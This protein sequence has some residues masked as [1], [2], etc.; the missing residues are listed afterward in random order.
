MIVSKRYFGIHHT[1][2]GNI[3]IFS[4]DVHNPHFQPLL[5]TDT[6]EQEVFTEKHPTPF[7]DYVLKSYDQ[8]FTN[9]QLSYL[10]LSEEL[11]FKLFTRQARYDKRKKMTECIMRNFFEDETIEYYNRINYD[12]S[13]LFITK[14]LLQSSNNNNKFLKIILDNLNHPY[15]N[16][17]VYFRLSKTCKRKIMY[18]YHT[19]YKPCAKDLNEIYE[20]VEQDYFNKCQE[21]SCHKRKKTV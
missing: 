5:T 11:K 4:L 9:S 7:N 13:V 16:E 17:L 18:A 2:V 19:D 8:L 14:K 10:K 20:L 3:W 1:D 12:V 15:I 21:V 6:L